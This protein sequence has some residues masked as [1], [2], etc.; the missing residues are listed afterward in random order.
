M[1]LVLNGSANTITGLAVGGLPNGVVDADTLA[2]GAVT[3]AKRGS[4]SILQFKPFTY[5][6]AVNFTSGNNNTGL[7]GSIT[8][9][10]SSN[11]IFVLA[12]QW[13]WSDTGPSE[14]K[15]GPSLWLQR[16][17]DATAYDNGNWVALSDANDKTWGWNNSNSNNSESFEL[18]AP[19]MQYDNPN[20]TGA[21]WYRMRAGRFTANTSNVKCQDASRGSF[22]YLMEIAA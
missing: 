10:S 18:M 17:T 2:D 3:A 15:Y 14:N 7:A 8:P 12:N 22:M 13:V 21:V 20:T 6:T 19:F 1:A 11:K 9:T 5:G 4:G 16:S